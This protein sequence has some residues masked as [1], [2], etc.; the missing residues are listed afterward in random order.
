MAEV[1]AVVV[2]AGRGTRMKGPDKQF[3][4]LSGMPVLRRTL[5]AFERT[6]VIT[7]IILVISPEKFG[8]WDIILKNWGINKLRAVV[9]GGNV[10]QQS[11][12]NGL[13]AVPFSCATVL[14]HDG[15][16]P[17]VTPGEIEAVA[18]AAREHGAATL[19]VP[20]KDTVKQADGQGFVESTPDRERLWLTQTPQGFSF[21]LLLEAHRRAVDAANATDDA[22]L[23]EMMGHRVK[24]VPGSYRNIKITTPEDI[25]IAEALLKSM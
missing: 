8:E 20:V 13:L 7:G 22:S 17:L 10:R 15:A 2:A 9:P 6:P 23:V 1:F 4:R 18:A 25:Y 11:V 24:L 5:A 12:M 19:A 14:I 3:I 21:S 16:R